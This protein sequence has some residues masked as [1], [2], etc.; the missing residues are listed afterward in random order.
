MTGLLPHGLLN[1]PRRLVILQYK[2]LK[3]MDFGLWQA[4]DF[5]F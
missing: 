1:R 2:P 5:R 4:A 3:K